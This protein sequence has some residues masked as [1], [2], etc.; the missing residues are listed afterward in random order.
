MAKR[1]QQTFK[2]RHLDTGAVTTLTRTQ[3]EE[4]LVGGL[5][6][7]LELAS[8]LDMPTPVV[9][10]LSACLAIGCREVSPAA[11]LAVGRRRLGRKEIDALIERTKHG[12]VG[13]ASGKRRRAARVVH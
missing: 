12:G 10:M 7:T 5:A 3:A 1:K 6:S 11:L 2:R 9:A 13:G 8:Q 4:L